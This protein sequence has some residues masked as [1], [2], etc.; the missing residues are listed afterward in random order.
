TRTLKG[1][2]IE[3]L[4]EVRSN[5]VQW[6]RLPQGLDPELLDILRAMLATNPEERYQDTSELARDLEY[7]IYKDGYGPTIVTLANYMRETMPGRFGD[8]IGSAAV[9]E[10]ERTVVIEDPDEKTLVMQ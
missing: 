10:D 1:E 3:V 5:N 8:P 7:Y 6:E 2:M 9:A 4:M